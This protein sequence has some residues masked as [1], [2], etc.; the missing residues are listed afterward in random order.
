MPAL[1]KVAAGDGNVLFE[2]EFP[3]SGLVELEEIGIRDKME[4][5]VAT[6]RAGAATIAD[7]IRHCADS[8]RGTFQDLAESRD[9]TGSLAE[10][11]VE[12][13]IGITGEG[14]AVVVKGSAEANLTVTLTWNFA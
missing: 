4:D 2:G 5:V 3:D 9:S 14:N 13:G 7:T 6:A 8:V 1:V 12:L 11:V 10:A